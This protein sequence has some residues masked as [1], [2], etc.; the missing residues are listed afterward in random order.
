MIQAFFRDELNANEQALVEEYFRQH[1]ERLQ[2]YLTDKSWEDFSGPETMEPAVSDKMLDVISSATYGKGRVRRMIYRWAS[3]AAV[4]FII[5]VSVFLL[6]DKKSTGDVKPVLAEETPAPGRDN[7]EWRTDSNS[8]GGKLRLSLEDGSVVELSKGSRI[9]YRKYFEPDSRNIWLTGS[10]LFDVGKDKARAFTVHAEGLDVTALGTVFRIYGSAGSD[11]RKTLEVSL[12]S[13]KIMVSP[14]SLLAIKGLKP[15][16]MLPGQTLVVD[17]QL[18]SMAFARPAEKARKVNDRTLSKIT[19]LTFNN[20]PLVN[21]L[22]TLSVAYGL[23]LIYRQELLK[24]MRFTGAFNSRRETLESF[25]GTLAVLYNLTIKQDKN[26][27]RI[28]Q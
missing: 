28:T 27:I 24:D 5:V 19:T 23:K 8:T 12:L 2:S 18:G 6:T 16:Y 11:D 9:R 21:I 17:K 4:L 7:V 15:V 3:V 22:D 26:I 25:L 14:D 20:E 10:A 1:P 13:G